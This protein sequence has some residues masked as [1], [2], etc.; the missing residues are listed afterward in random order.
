MKF[1][2]F[3][4]LIFL[5]SACTT[6]QTIPEAAPPTPAGRYD[7]SGVHLRL[8]NDSGQDWEA[9]TLTVGNQTGRSGMCIPVRWD[10]SGLSA[11]GHC[12]TW[13]PCFGAA[14]SFIP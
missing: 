13:F 4:S 1:I 14:R 3:L 8:H 12:I 11:S 7:F 5:L 2:R 6:T 9:V 10:G